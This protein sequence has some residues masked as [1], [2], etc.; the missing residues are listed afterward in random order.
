MFL[1]HC[2]DALVIV[3]GPKGLAKLPV[4]QLL[5]LPYRR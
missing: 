2:P 1:D 3:H 5:Q 4:R